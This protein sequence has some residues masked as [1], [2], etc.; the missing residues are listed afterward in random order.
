[1]KVNKCLQ[2]GRLE[3]ARWLDG[4]FEAVVPALR[5]PGGLYSPGP[6]GAGLIQA[7]HAPLARVQPSSSIPL[8]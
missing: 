3:R 5:R 2:N 7:F 6:V 4:V 1:M 8:Q